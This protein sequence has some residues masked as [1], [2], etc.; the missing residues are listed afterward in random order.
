MFCVDMSIKVLRMTFVKSIRKG[1]VWGTYIRKWFKSVD[2]NKRKSWRRSWEA[3][4][5]R[6]GHEEGEVCVIGKE[7]D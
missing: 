2:G 7:N 3:T 5:E 6:R 1:I 4:D